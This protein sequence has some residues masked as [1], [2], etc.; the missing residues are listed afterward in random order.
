VK[1]KQLLFLVSMMLFCACT[2]PDQKGQGKNDSIVSDSSSKFSDDLTPATAL[3]EWAKQLGLAEPHNMALVPEK[4]HL[5][6]AGEPDEAFNSVTLTYTGN[7]DT[8][9][10]QAALIAKAAKL[11]LSK[12]YVTMLKVA[13]RSGHSNRLKGVAY[14]NYDLS[15][16]D[17]DFLIYV[18]VDDKGTL[19]LSATD[20][21]QMNEQLK[22]H[23]GIANRM[24][25]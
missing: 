23:S 15:T 16:R 13:K 25:K 5:T 18:Q 10:N 20:M 2:S 11:P 8:A 17:I 3:P 21:I 14:M 1:I 6:S 7:Y 24:K 22:K 4:S 19:T 9:M 12:D